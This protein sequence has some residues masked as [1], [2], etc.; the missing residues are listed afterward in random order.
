MASSGF[1]PSLHRCIC[2]YSGSFHLK[3]RHLLIAAFSAKPLEKES[4]APK[5]IYD[6]D[7]DFQE[8]M[9]EVDNILETHLFPGEAIPSFRPG[10]SPGQMAGFLGA[11]I[12]GE[13]KN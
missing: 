1:G 13:N 5:R 8:V 4:P 10:F 6:P 2:A 9:K 7:M 3:L 12:E 11:P